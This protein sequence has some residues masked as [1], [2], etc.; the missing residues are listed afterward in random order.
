MVWRHGRCAF[1]F[2]CEDWNFDGPER[3]EDGLAYHRPDL[4][5]NVAVWAWKNETGFTTSLLGPSAIDGAR[6]TARLQCLYVSAGLGTAY[7][8]PRRCDRSCRC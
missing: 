2:L 4:H 6:R 1:A 8:V 3:T 5:I 7:D